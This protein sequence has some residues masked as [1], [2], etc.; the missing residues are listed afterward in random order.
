MEIIYPVSRLLATPKI[1]YAIAAHMGGPDAETIR[2]LFYELLEADF[3]EDA[4][5][6][7][8]FHASE[9]C[10]RESP[11][12]PGVIQVILDTGTAAELRPYGE[13]TTGI[14]SDNE[15]AITSNIYKR[16]VTAIEESRPEF[17]GDV[18]LCEPPTPSNEY[19]RSPDGDS[20]NGSFH[21][22]SDPDKTYDF[23]VEVI[24]L[25]NDKLKATIFGN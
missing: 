2:E 7:A 3:G 14:S 24:D 9:V 6:D 13:R 11:D 18:A 20:F 15:M 23:T 25:H 5:E 22:L 16:L 21:L 8:E 4:A 10:V 19:L 1:F 17:A 12:E